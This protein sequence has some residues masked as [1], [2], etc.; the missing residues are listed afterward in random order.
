MKSPTTV[1]RESRACAPPSRECCAD[2][3]LPSA[4][5]RAGATRR[6]RSRASIRDRSG[7]PQAHRGRVLV[8][9]IRHPVRRRR[10]RPA[11]RLPVLHRSSRPRADSIVV[12][13]ER[14][15]QRVITLGGLDYPFGYVLVEPGY[16]ETI[17]TGVSTDDELL[18]QV[19]WYFGLEEEGA[20]STSGH[21]VNGPGPRGPA[22]PGRRGR[23]AYAGT[24][25]WAAGSH[26]AGWCRRCS[27]RHTES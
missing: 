20:D 7:D 15:P 27:R 5:E 21:V 3:G 9:R 26:A 23:R 25:Y 18:D 2:R 6:P 19:G 17:L 13:L 24:Q 1:S 8:V 10:G 22:A 11:R 4:Q 14:G 12:E 16:A